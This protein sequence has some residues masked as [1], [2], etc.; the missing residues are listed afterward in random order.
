MLFRT[1]N[2]LLSTDLGAGPELVTG[3][4]FDDIGDDPARNIASWR[5]G[6]WDLYG[7]GLDG[8]VRALVVYDDGTGE[9]LYVG[10]GFG[11]ADGQS[12]DGLGRW[13]DGTWEPVGNNL[14]QVTAF[15][16]HD[17]GANTF[18]FGAGRLPGSSGSLSGS[19]NSSRSPQSPSAR[20]SAS[21]AARSARVARWSEVTASA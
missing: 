7:H 15:H 21:R 12:L 1:V 11:W 9:A 18:L 13:R 16:V 5:G 6:A 17:N 3:G 2:E 10:G 19:V 4:N 14:R 20:T 8:D